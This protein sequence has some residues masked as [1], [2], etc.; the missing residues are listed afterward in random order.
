MI[1]MS[2]VKMENGSETRMDRSII[3][4]I[5]KLLNVLGIDMYDDD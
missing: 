4:D 2:V 5:L 3:R 1:G